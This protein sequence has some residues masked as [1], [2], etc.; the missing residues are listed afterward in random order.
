M[1]ILPQESKIPEAPKKKFF[2]EIYAEKTKEMGT[3]PHNNQKIETTFVPNITTSKINGIDLALKEEGRLSEEKSKLINS[4]KKQK[5]LSEQKFWEFDNTTKDKE[6]RVIIRKIFDK[7]LIYQ[8]KL[9]N[10]SSK[11]M[12]KDYKKDEFKNNEKLIYVNDKIGKIKRKILFMKG[13]FDFAYPKMMIQKLKVNVQPKV[14]VRNKK[15]IIDI[16]GKL[17]NSPSRS[18]GLKIVNLSSKSDNMIQKQ[19][20]NNSSSN[21]FDYYTKITKNRRTF[22]KN[23]REV[24]SMPK[25][26]VISPFQINLVQANQI[27]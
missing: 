20:E 7:K 13:V 18:Q 5:Q 22:Y 6:T 21:G 27:I 4:N 24:N 17:V 9:D 12:I 3:N 8:L 1:S 23:S 25:I 11:E 2:H 14:E 19:K 15:D 26:N 16:R 10:R